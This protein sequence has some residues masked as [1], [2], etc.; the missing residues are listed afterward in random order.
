MAK[1]CGTCV[2]TNV[3]VCTT[4]VVGAALGSN[5]VCNCI[6]GYYE[7]N[8]ACQVC[9]AKCNGCQVNGVC[10][11]CADPNNRKLDQN[12]AC[13]AGLYDDGSA[14]CKTCNSLCKTCTNSTSCTSCFTENNRTLVNGQCVC[15]SGFYQVVNS[16]NTVT[17][18]KCSAECK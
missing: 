11:A 15:S 18:K 1:L 5:N 3:T 17:C 8:G 2:S 14:T 4:C 9:P 10:S 13:P 6:S 16:D 7:S 12:C